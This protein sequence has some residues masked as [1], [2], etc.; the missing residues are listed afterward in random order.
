VATA[1]QAIN[2]M[3]T[4]LPVRLNELTTMSGLHVSGAPTV[5]F[6]PDDVPVLTTKLVRGCFYAC[7][8]RPLPTGVPIRAGGFTGNPREIF[9]E[10]IERGMQPQGDYPF[11]FGFIKVDDVSGI[12][13]FTLWDYIA[14]HGMTGRLVEIADNSN[15]DESEPSHT[16]VV[17]F[18]S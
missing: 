6:R 9:D 11:R 13:L 12:W 10:A 17:G 14:L 5:R 2:A 18:E 16:V 4:P 7:A 8:G 15:P 3:W 1:G